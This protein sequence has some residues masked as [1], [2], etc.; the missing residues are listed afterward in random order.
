MKAGDDE[1]RHLKQI[2]WGGC[3]ETGRENLVG[4]R[5][6]EIQRAGA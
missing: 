2:S 3:G 6:P 1:S 5:D 4:S